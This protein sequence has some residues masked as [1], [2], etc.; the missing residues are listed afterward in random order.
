MFYFN[1]QAEKEFSLI[2]SFGFIQALKRLRP[3]HIMIYLVFTL[4][5]SVYQFKCESLPET[6]SQIHPGIGTLWPSQ[7][8]I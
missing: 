4:F 5:Y 7:V 6:E 8:N 2:M 3:P 1:S